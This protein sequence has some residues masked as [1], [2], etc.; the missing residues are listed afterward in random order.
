MSMVLSHN[1]FFIDWHEISVKISVSGE[2]KSVMLEN[3]FQYSQEKNIFQ[4]QKIRSTFSIIYVVVISNVCKL[5]DKIM[6]D[7]QHNNKVKMN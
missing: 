5:V 1:Y 4:V 2:L 6:V 7:R 3:L